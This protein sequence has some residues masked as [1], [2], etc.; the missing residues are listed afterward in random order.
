MGDDMKEQ[1]LADMLWW[2]K[3]VGDMLMGY[4]CRGSALTNFGGDVVQITAKGRQKLLDLRDTARREAFRAGAEAMRKAAIA[5]ML[6]TPHQSW[7]EAF[8]AISALP[9]PE[10]TE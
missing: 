5:A 6:E 1:E 3:A 9:L 10:V 7:G 2:K 4:T 8:D